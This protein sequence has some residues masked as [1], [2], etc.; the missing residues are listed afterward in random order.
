MKKKVLLVIDNL[1]SGGA[2]NQLTLLGVG[3]K[4]QGFD[5]SVF[6]YH[7]S[8]F[9]ASRLEKNNIPT[10][11]SSKKGKL[12]LSVIFSLA[13]K[14]NTDSYHAVISFLDTP[15]FY[16][17]LASF[18]SNKKTKLIVSYRSKT[19]FSEEGFINKTT[20]YLIN[21]NADVI[22]SNSY[23]ERNTWIKNYPSFEPKWN[24]IYNV[25][26]K[27]KFNRNPNAKR[28]DHFLVVGSVG[29]WKNGI[30]VI[31][32]IN[33][34]KKKGRIINLKW[35]GKKVLSRPI[36]KEYVEKMESLVKLYGLENQ[37]T[38]VDPTAKIEE[39][40][41]SCKALI[42]AS[43]TEGLPNVVC[44]A[45][46]CGTPCIVSNVLDHPILVKSGLNGLLFNPDNP[47]SLAGAISSIQEMSEDQY[48]NMKLNASK[49]ANKLFNFET[50]IN[51]YVNLI[52]N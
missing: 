42:L 39:E 48:D 38:W 32:A 22:V 1:G 49:Q 11:F 19:N 28:K 41:H 15:N 37:W 34:L 30:C 51:Q 43:K 35:I 3:L 20:K 45:L 40:Y 24:V 33:Y 18:I 36:R 13:K 6:T 29:P 7:K 8:V 5:V 47:E 10:I 21:K 25:V 26:D 46:S 44:E 23:H 50:F 12:G 27:K 2:Q 16:S 17:T 52:N 4:E 9:F 31:D 14:I